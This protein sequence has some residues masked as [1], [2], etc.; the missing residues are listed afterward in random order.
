MGKAIYLTILILSVAFSLGSEEFYRSDPSASRYDP[1]SSIEDG[2]VLGVSYDSNNSSMIET[3]YLN[4]K[5][6]GY[7]VTMELLDESHVSYYE[8]GILIN[9]KALSLDGRL[10]ST[11]EYLSDGKILKIMY[12]GL[13]DSVTKLSYYLDGEFQYQDTYLRGGDRT[14]QR[15]VRTYADGSKEERIILPSQTQDGGIFSVEGDDDLFR[16]YYSGSEGGLDYQRWVDGEL[17][18]GR[19]SEGTEGGLQVIQIIDGKGNKSKEFIDELDRIARKELYD[20]NNLLAEVHQFS[21]LDNLLVE[22]RVYTQNSSYRYVYE[23]DGET[24]LSETMYQQGSLKRTTNYLSD[25]LRTVTIYLDAI[26]TIST[27]LNKDMI[28]QTIEPYE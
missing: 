1:I 7:W 6:K 26:K 11:T 19:I 16:L 9:T 2:Y 22:K 5:I 20:Q 14:I 18:E 25:N 13:S 21:Y 27:Y 8:N 12:E 10:L 3:L 17:V 15:R 24:L 4:G 28:L 23:Y